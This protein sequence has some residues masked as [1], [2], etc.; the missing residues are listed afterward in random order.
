MLPLVFLPG[1]GGRAGFWQPVAERLADLG[2]ALR[3]AWPGF[4]DVPADSAIDSLGA[5]YLWFLERLPEGRCH[6]VAQSMGG[7]LAARLAIEHPERVATLVLCA[8]SGGVDVNAL[9]GADWRP[10]YRAELPDVPDWFMVDRT[11]LTDRLGAIRA[12][13]LV[14]Y[15]DADPI[16]PAAVAM[17]L[18]GRI[19]HAR[20]EVLAGAAHDAAHERPDEVAAAIRRHIGLAPAQRPLPGGQ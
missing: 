5:L 18:C 10:A 19:P 9:G 4:G 13:T 16:C 12:P 6:V 8:T 2:R 1:A 3:F 15:G 14:L 20:V 11:D 7:V 17:R